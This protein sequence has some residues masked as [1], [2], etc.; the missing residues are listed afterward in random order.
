MQGSYSAIE[1]LLEAT[2]YGIADHYRESYNDKRYIDIH[3][4]Q[5]PIRDS[6]KNGAFI[7]DLLVIAYAKLN[8]YNKE[9]PSRENSIALTSIQEAIMWLDMRKRERESRDVYGI[10]EA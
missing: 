4:Q 6:H 8:E 3:F 1:K 2:K 7:E 10:K 9:I 5:G